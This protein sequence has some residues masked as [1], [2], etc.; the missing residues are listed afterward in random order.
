MHPRRVTEHPEPAPARVRIDLNAR[1]YDGLYVL[2]RR[3]DATGPVQR[4]DT[5]TVF[6]PE[7]G[8]ATTATVKRCDDDWLHLDV[9]WDGMREIP[10]RE[11]GVWRDPQLAGRITDGMA[12]AE[13]G[14]TADLGSFARYL[15]EE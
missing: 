8:V 14:E 13:R 12:Q 5:V 2:A 11:L 9:D 6:E 3:S 15:S 1:T 10:A 4:G 7:D